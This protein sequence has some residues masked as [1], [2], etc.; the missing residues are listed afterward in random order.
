MLENWPPALQSGCPGTTARRWRAPR[1]HE[2]AWPKRILCGH[3]EVTF[4]NGPQPASQKEKIRYRFWQ[5]TEPGENVPGWVVCPCLDERSADP[6]DANTDVAGVLRPARLGDCSTGA[7]NRLRGYR[8]KSPRALD[9]G[10][11][12]PRNRCGPGLAP[13]SLGAVGDGPARHTAGTGASRRRVR[14]PDRSV[15][16]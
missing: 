11:A 7:R 16:P 13:G 1:Y 12:P 5:G 14:V 4:R 9:R 10:R 15:G 6:A 2:S 3:E 8:A